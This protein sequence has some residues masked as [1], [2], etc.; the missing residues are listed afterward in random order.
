MRYR[1]REKFSHYVDLFVLFV[2]LYIFINNLFELSYGFRPYIYQL[3]RILIAVFGFEL[4]IQFLL[5][6]GPR[7]YIRKYWPHYAILLALIFAYYRFSI[8]PRDTKLFFI[9]SK[10][11]LGVVEILLFIKF[12]LQFGRLRAI[13]GSFKVKPAQ[14]IVV[15]FASI[16]IVGSFLL[17]LPYSRPP[18]TD[19]RYIDVLFTSTSAVCGT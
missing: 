12:V 3:G 6:T 17:Y 7:A 10:L 8:V 11:F 9:Y 1:S 5:S 16:I 14:L 2:S 13:I 4:V 19:M 15:S 18:D